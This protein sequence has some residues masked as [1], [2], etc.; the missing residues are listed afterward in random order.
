[1]L[2]KPGDI[3]PDRIDI[4]QVR[5]RGD[6]VDDQHMGHCAGGKNGDM[7]VVALRLCA[8]AEVLDCHCHSG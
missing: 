8:A 7:I 6:A 1:M 3:T 2:H 4:V 5:H